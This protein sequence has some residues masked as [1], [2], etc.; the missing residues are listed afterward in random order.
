MDRDK[1]PQ[2]IGQ[3][4]A[5][6]S[7]R[8]TQPPQSQ[9]ST[10]IGKRLTLHKKPPVI[11]PESFP[12]QTMCRILKVSNVEDSPHHR[13]IVG[14]LDAYEKAGDF[15]KWDEFRKSFTEALLEVWGLIMVE[16]RR[17]G[18]INPHVRKGKIV[19]NQ[20]YPAWGNPIDD[21]TDLCTMCGRE[22][23]RRTMLESGEVK[24]RKAFK[25]EYQEPAPCWAV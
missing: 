14:M 11:M 6:M 1:P 3:T 22:C 2:A 21:Q 9:K 20:V 12:N 10:L 16:C 8:M 7:Y 13:A 24:R 25:P 17:N 23:E 19:F 18:F 4:S 5:V 15:R